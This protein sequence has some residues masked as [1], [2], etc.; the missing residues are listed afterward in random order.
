MTP[1]AA[2]INAVAQG[3]PGRGT[4]PQCLAKPPRSWS[5]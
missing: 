2:R 5:R 1:A 4:G 3:A